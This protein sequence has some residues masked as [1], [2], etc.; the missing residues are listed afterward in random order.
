MQSSNNSQCYFV[1]LQVDSFLDGELPETQQ[2]VF[3]GHVQSCAGCS[4]ELQFARS[5]HDAVLDLPLLDCPDTVLEPVYRISSAGSIAQPWWLAL[6]SWINAAPR[7]LRFAAPAFATL[8]VAIILNFDFSSDAPPP[9]IA[10]EESEQYSPE[11]IQQAL[12]DLNLAI[13]YLNEVSQRTEVMI[14]ERFLI[15][16][17]QDSINASFDRARPS[18]PDRSGQPAT[19]QNNPI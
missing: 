4:A 9:Q 16:P 13:D 6:W 10:A 14:G 12:K 18:R 19:I 7:S 1:Q 2:Q 5:L 3:L 15:D 17:I 11:E 8:L